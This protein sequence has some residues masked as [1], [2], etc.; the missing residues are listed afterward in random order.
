MD[1]DLISGEIAL[2]S[3]SAALS[4]DA[5]M[6]VVSLPVQVQL[7]PV[8]SLMSQ[9]RKYKAKKSRSTGCISSNPLLQLAEINDKWR[10]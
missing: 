3:V 9:T 4:P 5:S 10:L 6:A 1:Q 7:Q 8:G 2:E